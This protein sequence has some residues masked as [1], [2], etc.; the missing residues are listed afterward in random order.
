MD[1]DTIRKPLLLSAAAGCVAV[2]SYLA[3]K[4]GFASEN[5]QSAKMT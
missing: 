3:Y 5:A 1:S 2:A 4:V